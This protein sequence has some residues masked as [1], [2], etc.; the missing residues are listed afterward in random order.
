MRIAIEEVVA[1]K[2]V[3]AAIDADA[4]CLRFGKKELSLIPRIG[5]RLA[6][7]DSEARKPV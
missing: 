4:C 7:H 3:D 1:L 6:D 5:K 2:L